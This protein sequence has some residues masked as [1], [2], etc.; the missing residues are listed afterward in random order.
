MMLMLR[1][2]TKAHLERLIAEGIKESLTLDY[3]ASPSLGKADKQRDELCKDVTAFANSA[4][5]QVIYG[6]I[7]D[8]QIPVR[9]DDGAEPSIT[10]EWIE[11]VIDSRVQP[12]IEGLVIHLIQLAK[13]LGFVITVPPASSRAPHQA[14]D[15]RYYRRQNFQSVPMEDY[16]VRDTLR[17]ATAPDLFLELAFAMG[18]TVAPTFSHQHEVSNPIAVL[19]TLTNRS[20]QPAFH[21]L[22]KVGID[23]DLELSSATDFYPLGITGFDQQQYW[24]GKQI[25]SPPGLPVFREMD[26]VSFRYQINVTIHS[27]LLRGGDHLFH[28]ATSVA[29]PGFASQVDWKILQRG[30]TMRMCPPGRALN[31]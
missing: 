19:A 14:P 30:G 22:I 6:M 11:Q 2:E 29:C 25:A 13:G 4:G 12:R 31:P 20:N 28:L 17:R 8:K 9:L 23:T 1:L 5:G 26:P 15:K 10:K 7:D 27:S 3:K 21:A 16:E 24:L 18:P